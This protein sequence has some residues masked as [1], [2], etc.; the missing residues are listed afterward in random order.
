MANIILVG[1]TC[2]GKT[3]V[4]KRLAG[5]LGLR[6]IDSDDLIEQRAGKPAARILAEDGEA[7]LRRVE[8]EVVASL[9]KGR[10]QVVATG[11]GMLADR[12]NRSELQRS[13]T[14]ICLTASPAAILE[15]AMQGPPRPFLQCKN[16][17]AGIAELMAEHA[18][19][20][21]QA[22][23]TIDTTGST[24]DDVV[25]RILDIL[26]RVHVSL[27]DRS[28]DIAIGRGV[29][30]ETQQY[31]TALD[32]HSQTIVISEQRVW[33]FHGKALSAGLPRHKRIILPGLDDQEKLK[34][35]RYAEQLYDELL[36]MGAQRDSL[37]IAFGGGTVGDLVGFVAATYMRGIDFIQVP[38]TLLAQVDSSVGGK[39][40]VNHLR[41]KNLIGAFWQPRF[42]L[43]DLH[44]LDTL[45]RQQIRNGLG[46]VVKVA[47][48][49]DARLF[50]YL[51]DHVDDIL[52]LRAS[53][54]HHILRRNCQIKAAIVGAD[55]REAGARATLNLGHTFAHGLEAAVDYHGIAHGEAVSIGMVMAAR[56]ARDLGMFNDTSLERLIALLQALR[57]PI[58][59]PSSVPTDAI[60]AAM[61][62]DKK[63]RGGKLRFVLPEKIG[64]V[65]VVSDVPPAAVRKV[66]NGTGNP[67]SRRK[68]A[69]G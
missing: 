42:V 64:R 37:L 24:A 39:V 14:V 20:Y 66:L 9:V 55:E 38:T 31:L 29:L 1:F 53:V 18:P 28:Y 57:M 59:P 10:G 33:D 17:A 36:R 26:D 19:L 11:A 54:M 12:R 68:P 25:E 15:R 46:E 22:D 23:H 3:Q 35:L 6:F 7:A 51:E 52:R 58:Q 67:G 34:S 45:P 2:T 8:R 40:A 61:K 47:M 56:M 60:L 5:T 63:V 32:G 41:A 65:R 43:A 13:G 49:A 50:R 21:A 27:G 48:L 4:G 69:D 16:P 30:A 62:T 44:C